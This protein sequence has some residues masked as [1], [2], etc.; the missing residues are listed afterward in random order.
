MTLV[1][2]CGS[3]LYKNYY[4][5]IVF[6]SSGLADREGQ[7]V[8][9]DRS[10]N[11]STLKNK[12]NKLADVPEPNST[13]L[14]LNI[15]VVDP[16]TLKKIEQCDYCRD[17]IGNE[18]VLKKT[19]VEFKGSLFDIKKTAKSKAIL[20]QENEIQVQLRM[21]CQSMEKTHQQPDK[22][23]FY[24]EVC[25]TNGK[26]LYRAVFSSRVVS[27]AFKYKQDRDKPCKIALTSVEE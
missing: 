6:R 2:E 27:Y 12:E 9:I 17:S 22:F 8:Y 16:Y 23:H 24:C 26:V 3:N 7:R 15:A 1:Q 20:V 10:V 13:G 14:V 5:T 19:P 21:M 11:L 25:D 4:K 18:G